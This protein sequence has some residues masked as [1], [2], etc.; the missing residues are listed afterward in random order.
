[1]ILVHI[2]PEYFLFSYFKE[3]WFMFS[4]KISKNYIFSSYDKHS[5]IVGPFTCLFCSKKLIFNMQLHSFHSNTD[6]TWIVY[7]WAILEDQ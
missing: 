4:E 2:I 3:F 6:R 7:N 1:M 5:D